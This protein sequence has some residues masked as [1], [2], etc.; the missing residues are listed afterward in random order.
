MAYNNRGIARFNLEQYAE[1]VND[2]NRAIELNPVFTQ[3]YNNRGNAR[4]KLNDYQGAM[5]DYSQA[6]ELNPA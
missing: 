3:A 1:A 5:A 2:F 6:I 4:Y